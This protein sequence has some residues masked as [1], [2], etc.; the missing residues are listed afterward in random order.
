[1]SEQLTKSVSISA[2]PVTLEWMIVEI[3]KIPQEYWPHLFEMICLYRKTVEMK[4]SSPDS[5]EKFNKEDLK[6]P[7]PLVAAAKQKA[8]SELLRS[9]REE[10]DEEEQ[11]ETWE[12]LSKAL[13]QGGVSI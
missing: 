8:L 3:D 11:K 13:D 7:N 10:G 12:I 5:K 6:N 4:V 1:M 9:W 2:N